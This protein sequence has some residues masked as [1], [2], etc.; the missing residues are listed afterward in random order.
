M[1]CYRIS[2]M[3]SVMIKQQRRHESLSV[4]QQHQCQQRQC[5]NL[6]RFRSSD[7]GG[8]SNDVGGQSSDHSSGKKKG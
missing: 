8:T 5:S 2:V 3:L 1:Q 6:C 4:F 7:N